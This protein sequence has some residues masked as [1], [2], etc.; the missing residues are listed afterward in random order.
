MLYRRIREFISE[1]TL[2]KNDNVM[3]LTLEHVYE[4]THESKLINT[5]IH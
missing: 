5:Y 1:A 3:L 4:Q 2:S